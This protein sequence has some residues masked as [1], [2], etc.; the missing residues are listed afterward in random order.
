MA[1]TSTTD[2]SLSYTTFESMDPF[3]NNTD[4][5][6]RLSYDHLVFLGVCMGISLCGLAANGIV[7][8]F[9][10]SHMRNPFTVYVLNLS[11][12]DFSLL[13][14]LFLLM[15]AILSL[16]ICSLLRDIILYYIKLEII[17]GF[18][19]HFFDLSS[20]GLLTAISVDRCVSVF[21]PIWY[22]CHR[23]KHLSGIVSG[24]LWALAGSFVSSM[25]LSFHFE[26]PYEESFGGIAI[27]ITVILSSMMLISNLSLFI[28]LR[29]GFRRRHPGK[30]YVAVLLN[31]IFFFVFAIPFSIEVFLNLPVTQDLFPHKVSFLLALLNS[32][33]NPVV[34]F[35]VGSCRRRRIQGS[36]KAAFRRV[37]EEKAVSE[38]GSRTPRDTA[39]ETAV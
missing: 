13:L 15:L 20:L 35:L 1:E 34:Y 4:M 3:R 22:R 2:L 26:V 32:S 9:L 25:Y 38:E 7:M 5:C 36:V 8:W 12:A 10:F 37:F 30:L 17:V 18:L 29:C 31:V 14:F 16:T 11:V 21:F 27:A 6:L 39:S 24:L 19:C 28:K 33:T 23:P